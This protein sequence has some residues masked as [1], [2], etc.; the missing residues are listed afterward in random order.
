MKTKTRQFTTEEHELTITGKDLL[1]VLRAAM[2][3]DLT[4]NVTA[5]VTVHVPGG[6]DWSNTDLDIDECPIIVRW[7]VTHRG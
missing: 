5:K 3:C 6:G 1:R 2:V 7:E 4:E